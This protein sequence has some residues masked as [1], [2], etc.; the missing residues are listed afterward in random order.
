LSGSARTASATGFDESTLYYSRIVAYGDIGNFAS[1]VASATTNS[2]VLR[3]AP[4]PPRNVILVALTSR[5]ARVRW[6]PSDDSATSFSILFGG[7]GATP[8]AVYSSGISASA[9][10]ADI[11]GLDPNTQYDIVVR[12]TNGVGSGDSNRL[13]IRTQGEQSSSGP[14]ARNLAQVQTARPW[15]KDDANVVV[16]D[17]TRSIRVICWHAAAADA[18]DGPHVELFRGLQVLTPANAAGTSKLVDTIVAA[19]EAV[20]IQVRGT[21]TGESNHVLLFE[22]L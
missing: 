12:A 19:G 8:L 14:V 7:A 11:A 4:V 15:K 20:T 21:D 22:Y 5:A 13:T 16:S 3:P 9:R 2:T 17:G 18:T 6:T 10:E 1:N